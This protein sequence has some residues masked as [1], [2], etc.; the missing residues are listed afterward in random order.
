MWFAL[1]RLALGLS[2]IALA[3][4]VLLLSDR[5]RRK[6]APHAFPQIAVL[7]H[8]SQAVAD[9]GVQGMLDGLA[10]T[11]FVPGK[12]ITIKRFNAEN[13]L[14]TA[15]AIAKEITEGDFSLVLTAT[16]LSLQAVAKANQAGRIKHVFGLVT[17]PF[18][19]GVGISR[20][21]P[22][23]HPKHLVGYGTFQP[24]EKSFRLAKQFLPTLTTVGV[25]WNPAESN[26]EASTRQ[27]R[28]ISREL[29]ITLLETNVDNSSGVFEAANSLVS[30]GVEAL[31]VGGDVTVIVAFDALAEAAKKGRIPVFTNIPPLAERGALFDLGADYHEVGRLA[32]VLAGDVLHGADPA[33]IPVK[34]VVPERLVINQQT[35]DGL[36]ETWHIPEDVVRSADELVDR[37]GVHKQSRATTLRTPPPGRVFKVGVVYFGP[38]P[39]TESGLQGLLDGLDELGFHQGKNLEV[40]SQ[41]AQGEI[42][43]IPSIIQNFLNQDLDLIVPLTTPCLAAAASMVKTKPV[44]FAVVYDPIAAGAGTSRTDHLPNITGVGSFPPVA[45]TVALIRQLVPGIRSVGTLYNS[46]EANSRKVIGVSRE[47]FRKEGIALEEVAIGSSSEVFQG[48]QALVTRH[49]Q[50]VW[51]TGDNTALQAFDGIVKSTRDARL[52]LIINDPEFIGRGALACAGLGFYKSGY[53][54]AKLAARVLLGENPNNLA[55]EE[56]ADKK[57]CINFEAA[58]AFGSPFPPELLQKVSFVAHLA[59]KFGRPAKLALIYPH[60]G[61]IDRQQQEHLIKALGEAGLVLDTDITLKTYPAKAGHPRAVDASAPLQKDGADAILLADRSIQEEIPPAE[62]EAPLI[63]LSDY[64]LPSPIGHTIAQP[65]AFDHH[66][67]ALAIVRALAAAP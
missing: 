1:K 43:N 42:V 63:V 62:R 58:K 40:R 15:N 49:V 65:A 10:E 33:A 26:S 24:V 66:A 53:A 28:S 5:D 30:R 36:R 25:V 4:G 59:S 9:E 57:T 12:T 56:V 19:A 17:D 2:L 47:L 34:N 16:T 38:D 14:P 45:D 18:G 31:W 50:A 6:T 35:L 23:N 20:E 3:S 22:L 67:A 21:N 41:H 60:D 61:A 29:G 46:S 48:A 27:A 44:V 64:K 7:Q 52:P 32:G 39:V 54:A 11:G 55:F 13:D 37:T 51:I 8:A